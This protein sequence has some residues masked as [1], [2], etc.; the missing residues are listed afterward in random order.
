VVAVSLVQ[1]TTSPGL[2]RDSVFCDNAGRVIKTRN[3]AGDSTRYAYNAASWLDSISKFGPDTVAPNPI[4]AMTT[5]MGYD[6]DGNRTSITDP[7]NII[8]R[9]YFDAVGRD[10]A[11]LDE[12]GLMELRRYDLEGNPV[13]SHNRMGDSVVT[14][15][16]E[17]NRDTLRILGDVKIK[18]GQDAFR[19]DSLMHFLMGT[20]IVP[21]DTVRTTYDAAGRPLTI[22]NRASLITHVHDGRCAGFGNARPGRHRR[23]FQLPVQPQRAAQAND[24]ASARSELRV[25]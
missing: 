11:T 1:V 4:V 22:T 13:S 18:P 23:Q 5:R 21:G 14:A 3:A 10:T 19:S 20:A 12:A 2:K 15:Y 24:D 6:A 16:D 9:S 8:R 17:V 25:R 7:R